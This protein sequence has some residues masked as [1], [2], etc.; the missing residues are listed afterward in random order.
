LRELFDEM[1]ADEPHCGPGSTR[2]RRPGAGCR[3]AA[4]HCGR[5]RRPPWPRRWRSACRRCPPGRPAAPAPPSRQDSRPAR[6]RLGRPRYR[7]QWSPDDAVGPLPASRSGALPPAAAPTASVCPTR[8]GVCR[9][10]G[11][12][13]R[14]APGGGSSS[15]TATVSRD[16]KLAGISGQAQSSTF[17]NDRPGTVR[18]TFRSCQPGQRPAGRAGRGRPQPAQRLRRGPRPDFR[19]AVS[20]SRRARPPGDLDAGVV[21]LQSSSARRGRRAAAQAGRI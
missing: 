3:P 20:T 10:P 16:D 5:S 21:R 4:G 7:P 6:Q 19:T 1:V 11:R 2:P 12:G 9:R 13:R 8:P 17:G 18:S 14:I 15:T